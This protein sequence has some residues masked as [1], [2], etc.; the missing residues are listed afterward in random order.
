MTDDEAR[1]QA[2]QVDLTWREV[3]D[4]VVVLDLRSSQYLSLNKSGAYLWK[5]IAEPVGAGALVDALVERYALDRDR[6]VVDVDAF[7]A[8]CA[9][10]GRSEPRAGAARPAS[11]IRGRRRP[12]AG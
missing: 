2:R 12:P 5:L 7:V 11:P 8:A 10:S 4:E 1:V 6:A 3:D 9:A